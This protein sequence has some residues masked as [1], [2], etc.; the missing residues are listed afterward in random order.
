MADARSR[1]ERL[2][3][4]VRFWHRAAIEAGARP[5]FASREERDL[6]QEVV[7]GER[8]ERVHG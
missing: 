2:E 7:N 4:L 1:E 6:H 5:T 3:D 8:Q